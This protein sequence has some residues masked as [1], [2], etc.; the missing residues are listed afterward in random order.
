MEA[1]EDLAL[2]LRAH[3][4][5]VSRGIDD[6]AEQNGQLTT[7]RLRF[8]ERKAALITELRLNP[9]DGAAPSAARAM[10]H[11]DGLADPQPF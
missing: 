7:A 6:I 8:S 3:R 2:G 4:F 11:S 10:A 9:R 5:D 1:S